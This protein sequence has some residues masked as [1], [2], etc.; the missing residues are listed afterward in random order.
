MRI[1]FVGMF[2]ALF[3]V[4]ACETTPDDAASTAGAGAATGAT[5]ETGVGSAAVA[6][7]A[8]GMTPES[9]AVAPGGT[10]A[11]GLAALP[12]EPSAGAREPAEV[13][14]A[15]AAVSPGTLEDFVLNVGDTVYFDFD[16]S[17]LTP[18]A[19]ST[20]ERQA[21]WLAQFPGASLTVQ[22]HCDERGTRE[23]NLALGERRATAVKNFLS[24]LG[25]D[26]NRISI[27]SFGKE[28]P[29]A[30]GHNEA[31]WAQNRRGVTV[32]N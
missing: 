10:G 18:Q 27:I 3:L 16:S 21:A 13:G 19:Q 26:L 30:L 23:Y 5:G 12:P 22:G 9:A 6:P 14:R 15:V 32:I 8:G 25:V 4:A 1:T 31:A 7:G 17:V 29:A 11:P 2:A 24:A 20:L 28:R